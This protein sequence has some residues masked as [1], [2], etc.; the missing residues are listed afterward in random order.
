MNRPFVL[1]LLILAVSCQKPVTRVSLQRTQENTV[2]KQDAVKGTFFITQPAKDECWDVRDQEIGSFNARIQ[3]VKPCHSNQH[4]MFRISLDSDGWHRISTQYPTN[5][6]VKENG[7]PGEPLIASSGSDSID[8]PVPSSRWSVE[9][10]GTSGN[11]ITV[12][13]RSDLVMVDG[14]RALCADRPT[15]ADDKIQIYFC[16]GGATQQWVLVPTSATPQ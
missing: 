6:S 1:L 15:D 12:F 7:G 14:N 5:Y 8:G 11:T 4:N 2:P 16:N 3:P 10:I 9:V 13:I